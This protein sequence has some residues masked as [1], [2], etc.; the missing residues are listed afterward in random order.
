[1]EIRHIVV[2]VKRI[3]NPD[4]VCLERLEHFLK[5]AERLGLTVL[6][7]GLRPDLLEALRRLHFSDW[8]PVDRIFAQ[9]RDDD[10]A[11]LA[12]IRS[13]YDRLGDTNA[14]NHCIP[15]ERSQGCHQQAL[16][17]GLRLVDAASGLSCLF[18]ERDR[19]SADSAIAF[20]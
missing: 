18:P 13:V 3:R 4:V 12:A 11:T 2:R 17:P 15:N 7:A 8:F 5:K 6:F 20:D 1:M 16:L 14:C 10:S 9:V 19:A